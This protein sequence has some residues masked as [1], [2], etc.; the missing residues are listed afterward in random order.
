[1]AA[2]L[3]SALA[4]SLALAGI[5]QSTT[6]PGND[7]TLAAAVAAPSRYI[8]L[9]EE[10]AIANFQKRDGTIDVRGF[11]TT[12]SSH[13]EKNTK[14]A[15]T[16]DSSLFRGVS[17]D[18]HD[19]N[20]TSVDQIKAIEGVSQVWPAGLFTIPPTSEAVISNSDRPTWS[21]HNTT[22][23]NEVH[24][25][26]QK[27]DG[28]IVAMIDSGVDYN[29]PALGAG[30]GPGF[31]VEGGY[32]L[33]GD[34]YSPGG[35]TNPDS[36]P[37]DC[38]GHGTHV[39]GI[40]AS[41]NE[42][43]PGVAPN[44]RLRMYKVFGC[45]DGTTE[46]VVIAGFLRAFEEG[47]DVITAS[48]GS[49]LGFPYIAASIVVS[50]IQAAGV[51][52]TAAAGNSGSAGPFWTTNLGNGFGT[53]TVG[54]VEQSDRVVYTVK[55]RSANG[56]TRDI[57][58]MEP[59]GRPFDLV[60]DHSAFFY[61]DVRTRDV[62]DFL[63]TQPRVPKGDVLVQR[64][65]D[66][67]WSRMDLITWG[68]VEW[69]FYYGKQGEGLPVPNRFIQDA[70][71]QAKGLAGIT[72]ED[73]QWLLQHSDNNITVTF[74]FEE[75][76]RPVS[77]RWTDANGV[78]TS[79]FSSWGPTLDCRMKPEIAAPGATILSTY[80]L[81]LGKW[82]TLSGTSM[83]TPYIAGVAALI[84]GSKGGRAGWG[85]DAARLVH[86]RLIASG[87][88]VSMR[89][90]NSAYTPVAKIGAGIVDAV[91]A[92]EYDTFVS[93]ANLN[94]NDT[95]HFNG[96]H[97]IKLTN[98]GQEVV[99][100]NATHQNLNGFQ[101]VSISTKYVD[102][103][104]DIAGYF[105]SVTLSTES[106]TIGPG[107]TVEITASFTEPDNGVYGLM[108]V[109]GGNIHFWGSNGED[110]RVT[111]MGIK[112]SLYSQ[113]SWLYTPS[114]FQN[115]NS[116]SLNGFPDGEEYFIGEWEKQ[117][118]ALYTNS[119][120]SEEQSFDYVAK[121]WTPEDW[122]YPPFPGKN[123]WFGSMT[124][125]ERV[126]LALFQP[127]IPTGRMFAHGSMNFS[128]GTTLVPGEYR[129]LARSLRIYGDRSNLDDWQTALSNWFTLK[130]LPPSNS[131]TTTTSQTATS[132]STTAPTSAAPLPPIAVCGESVPINLTAR[133]TTETSRYGLMLSSDF[134]VYDRRGDGTHF[135]W[136][137]TNEGYLKTRDISRTTP[138]D[139]YAAVHS[140]NN[141]LIYMYT[142]GQ[143]SGAFSYLT[144]ARQGTEL[145]CTA[146][147]KSS[148]YDCQDPKDNEAYVH[149]RSGPEVR[150]GCRQVTFNFEDLPQTCDTLAASSPATVSATPTMSLMI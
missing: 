144:C 101:A 110:V 64:Q 39:A 21:P 41:Q 68:R 125:S 76:P 104:P 83:A 90:D 49:A 55:A 31:K 6:V 150:S 53:T 29:H 119:W 58:Y 139:I 86:E 37:M 75:N 98:R 87:Q 12:V 51:V 78:R 18:V 127:R 81:K 10:G 27:G 128:Q 67:D 17:V 126:F 82:A 73:G 134:L 148:F 120:A 34:N 116:D 69:V 19:A 145:L 138:V 42:Y 94:L 149:I 70:G 7:A 8:V 33:A 43:N 141:S 11:A 13:I 9:F 3:L 80:P 143:I 142:P 56:T 38:A 91:R 24:Q 44:A 14:P 46:D 63:T 23:V 74:E 26:G 118:A 71:A 85:S 59:T 103:N 32:D 132:T 84:L 129:I 1:M 57:V 36:D 28:V 61:P 113:N 123:K 2:K 72:Y 136:A 79:A 60:G 92:V 137:L 133:I 108:P 16:F 130:A 5:G 107:E 96:V 50:K 146:N 121:D 52:V 65:G 66:C 54:S 47:A 99:T 97:T 100:Y 112:G 45:E 131:T 48:L 40:I 88:P 124:S 147:A 117:P 77:H 114:F 25:K 89:N 106:V 102:T 93:P 22:R 111:Y 35:P 4:A 135:E 115:K 30:F 105:A 95:V 20:S 109:Y 62:C 122:V 15:L 140:N